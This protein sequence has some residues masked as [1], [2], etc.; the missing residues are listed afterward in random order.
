M[1]ILGAWASK[2]PQVLQEKKTALKG[3]IE[4]SK[5]IGPGS[6]LGAMPYRPVLRLVVW[7]ILGPF[8][9]AQEC[10]KNK[11]IILFSKNS[12]I[13]NKK[14]FKKYIYFLDCYI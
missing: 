12:K 5:I 6:V 8:L 9:E 14:L 13:N 1:H 10:F 4:S 11:S 2:W 7:V 3:L